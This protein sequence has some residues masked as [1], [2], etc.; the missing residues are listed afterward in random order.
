MRW[1]STLILLEV[2][3]SMML[4]VGAGLLLRSFISLQGVD[5]GF[6]TQHVLAMNINLPDL[7][8]P[9]PERRLAFFEALSE[10][11][12]ALPG[13]EAAAFANRMPMRGGWGGGVQVEVKGAIQENLEADMQAV[14]SGYFQTLGLELRRGRLLAA[15]DRSGT[16]SPL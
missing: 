12:G 14:N 1:R 2:S 11:I 8:Y 5:L 15:A 6:S 3:L 13:V 10:K 7:R 9:D 4:L 16:F